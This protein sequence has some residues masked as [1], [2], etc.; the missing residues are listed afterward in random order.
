M[1]GMLGGCA[2]AIEVD[3]DSLDAVAA[4]LTAWRFVQ[5]SATPLRGPREGP[6]WLPVPQV[7]VR[8]TYAP[9]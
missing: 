1:G 9:I 2:V 3:H 7:E 6:I 5:G 4:A 8:D